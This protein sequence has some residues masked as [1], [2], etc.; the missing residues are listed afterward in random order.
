MVTRKFAKITVEELKNKVNAA[1]MM[2]EDGDDEFDLF[3]FHE[4][5]EDD[6]KVRMDFENFYSERVGDEGEGEADPADM[7]GYHTIGEFSFMGAEAGGDWEAPV[8]FIVYW[9]GSRLR[10]YAPTEGNPWNRKTKRAFGNDNESD[11]KELAKLWGNKESD[12]PFRVPPSD[13]AKIRQDIMAR[14]GLAGAA[15]P[16]DRPFCNYPVGEKHEEEDCGKDA[17][18]SGDGQNY[19]AE[20]ASMLIKR[21]LSLERACRRAAE[22]LQ[23]QR[24]LPTGDES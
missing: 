22:I 6:L 15:A 19:C 8:F 24:V 2:E 17:V 9:D 5:I 21:G 13:W 7:R 12:G 23:Q 20:H 11:Q 14:F 16:V 3:L 18:V 4:K 1:G 10:A